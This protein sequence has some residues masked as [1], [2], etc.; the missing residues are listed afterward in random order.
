MIRR[1]PRSTLFPYTTLF[2]SQSLEQVLM[3][4]LAFLAVDWFAGIAALLMEPGEERGLSWLVLLQR[5]VYRQVLYWAV[6]KAV[7]AAAQGPAPGLGKLVRKGTVELPRA[8][9]CHPGRSRSARC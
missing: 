9:P 5:F 2:R 7:V 8:A 3:Y 1:P 6:V 4:Y